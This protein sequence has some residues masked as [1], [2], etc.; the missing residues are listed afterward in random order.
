MGKKRSTLLDILQYG[1]LRAFVAFIRLMPLSVAVLVGRVMAYAGYLVDRKR[2]T[3]ARENLR[4]AYGDD[5]SD[6]EI[7]KIKPKTHYS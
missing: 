2:R 1:G 7:E 6:R 5:L 3:I 4:K